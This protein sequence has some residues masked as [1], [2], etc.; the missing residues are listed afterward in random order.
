MACP[1][2]SVPVRRLTL[3]TLTR[4]ETLGH[5]L[6]KSRSRHHRSR[7]SILP[8][9]STA[10]GPPHEYAHASQSVANL[11]GH[12]VLSVW[13][14]AISGNQTFSLAQH[15]YVAEGHTG[16]Q[17]AEV[18]WQV[19]PELYG[20]A[21]PVLFVYW[22]ADG[23][24]ATGSY[25]LDG[26]HFVQVSPTCPVGIAIDPTSVSGGAQVELELTYLLSDGKWWLYVNGTDPANA[27]GYFPVDLYAGGPM[28]TAAEEID[29]GGETVG[30]G[31]Y[32]PMGSGVFASQGYRSSAYQRNI[33][34]YPP[35]GGSANAS[36]TPSEDWPQ[37]YTIAV[38]T[39][40]D[41]GEYFYFGGPGSAAAARAPSLAAANGRVL[42]GTL[43]QSFHS[44][45]DGL[46]RATAV[47]NGDRAA[48]FPNGIAKLEIRVTDSDIVVN[49]SAAK[50][51]PS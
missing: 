33:Y 39:S 38:G 10:S 34:Y 18:G 9:A 15:W 41:W 25:N 8:D 5:F 16:L 2:G 20:H 32:P 1:A 36:L 30:N 43:K 37:S 45:V 12:S 50:E 31:S 22:T 28:A 35:G 42:K 46:I 7:I 47:R 14:P 11:G 23:Y 17:T 19:Y 27:V 26:G 4:F 49:V 51:S 48:F 3:E 40:Q 6:R 13:D 21:K 44:A 24:Q 29:Y